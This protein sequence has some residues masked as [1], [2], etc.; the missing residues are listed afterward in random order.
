[1]QNPTS[2]DGRI[3]SSNLLS[4]FNVWHKRPKTCCLTGLVYVPWIRL[5]NSFIFCFCLLLI[6]SLC[7][8]TRLICIIENVHTIYPFDLMAVCKPVE[9]GKPPPTGLEC[10]I[11]DL[12]TFK[13]KKKRRRKSSLLVMF[14]SKKNVIRCLYVPCNA[15]PIRF[16]IVKL[17]LAPLNDD[18]ST[19]LSPLASPCIDKGP[20]VHIQVVRN[21]HICQLGVFKLC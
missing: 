19:L 1:M 13:K 14:P 7:V 10:G 3:I 20:A 12:Q 21:V 6:V 2:T 16:S 18:A 5:N 9:G 15:S 17:T 8:N 11:V 4:Q